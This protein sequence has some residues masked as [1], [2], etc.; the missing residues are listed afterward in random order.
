MCGIP[1]LCFLGAVTARLDIATSCSSLVKDFQRLEKIPVIVLL[2]SKS[3]DSVPRVEHV[4]Y[5]W[6]EMLSS[7]TT[8]IRRT[9]STSASE[10]TTTT[11]HDATSTFDPFG[12]AALT[13]SSSPLSQDHH[14]DHHPQRT[15]TSSTNRS[16]RSIVKPPNVSRVTTTT[17]AAAT[18]STTTTSS[19]TT[20]STASRTTRQH[21]QSQQQR[22]QH[23][24]QAPNHHAT[25]ALPPHMRIKIAIHEEVSSTATKPSNN[26]NVTTTPASGG[27][28]NTIAF[29]QGTI[30]AFVVSSD[31]H[32]NHPFAITVT[33]TNDTAANATS[34]PTSNTTSVLPV[35]IRPVPEYTYKDTMSNT[36]ITATTTT[37]SSNS[38]SFESNTMIV[39]HIPKQV[40]TYVPIAYYSI[41]QEIPH[42]PILVE[43]KV[44]TI[45][46]SVRLAIQ[47]RSK[48]SNTSDIRHV[49]IAVAIPERVD[50]PS[51]SITRGTT[52]GHYDDLKRML[53]WRFDTL[54]TGQS[55]LVTAQGKLWQA[56]QNAHDHVV[57]DDADDTADPILSSS[58]KHH[59]NDHQYGDSTKS[60]ETLN[61]PVVVRCH[62]STDSIVGTHR[63]QVHV[64][65]APGYPASVT[66][67]M[68][69]T[70]FQLLHRL[71]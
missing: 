1:F 48:I 60:E 10:Y 55:I 50:G 37:A 32:Q 11:D 61:F 38:S 5:H 8:L 56:I 67:D 69:P 57:H 12:I 44:T 27:S 35:P 17:A 15:G 36:T 23:Y 33:A 65:Q 63:I 9:G 26:N 19:P 13:L 51:L 49:V 16:H 47:I 70:S 53:M 59:N 25:T 54:P 64:H 7:S 22:H 29:V 18:S 68:G 42:M 24:Q 21:H 40:V 20:G 31:A 34:G 43:R 4:Y 62:S 46:T 71:T 52:H 3:D 14:L 6:E 39:S 58:T 28:A 45:D 66:Y 2:G 30:S 41:H